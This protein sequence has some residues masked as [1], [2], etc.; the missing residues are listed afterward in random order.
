MLNFGTRYSRSKENIKHAHAFSALST[1]IRSLDLY[2]TYDCFQVNT[3]EST[4][5]K[6]TNLKNLNSYTRN[7]SLVWVMQASARIT[8]RLASTVGIEASKNVAPKV[9]KIYNRAFIDSIRVKFYGGRGGNGCISMLS[10]FAN[11]FAGPD[12]GNG[13]NGGHIVLRANSMVKSLNN[14]AHV[15]RGKPGIKGMSKNLY[16]ANAEHTFVDVPVGT[17]VLPAKPK[18]LGDHEYDPDKSDII[19][20]LDVEGSMF[21]AARGGA[22]GKGNAY[23][24]SNTNRHPRIAEAGAFGDE[25]TYE[26]RIKVYAHVGLIGLPNAGKSTLLKTLTGA[27]VR[28]GD[29][30]FTTLHPQVGVVEFEDFSQMAISDLPGLI[31][32]SHKNRGLGLQFLRSLQRC[33]C[34]LYVVDMS[35]TNPVQQFETL[36]GELEAHK[37]GMSERPHLV[38][39]NK[40]DHPAAQANTETFK[41]HLESTRP[42]TKLLFASS[43][44][45]D[46]LEQ[47]REELKRLHD[48]YQAKNA[49]EID[50]RLTW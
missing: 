10:L 43:Q 49:D 45:G 29:Y 7:R 4:E 48:E 28:I 12:G 5:L 2:R 39:G 3:H 46:G 6:R 24:L 40:I 44:S 22:G 1:F 41:R 37:E 42:G 30:A 38:L 15:Y 18:E 33:A 26:L 16:G 11:E 34:L 8:S 14:V 27:Q 17:L 32:D 21:I 36:I 23:Y 13:G 25:N 47:L 19:A 20:E 35:A 9:K 31:E 50:Q